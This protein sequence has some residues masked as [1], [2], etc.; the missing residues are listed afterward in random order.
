MFQ[1]QAFGNVL[2]QTVTSHRP[3]CKTILVNMYTPL[4]LSLSLALSLSLPCLLFL[5][6]IVWL[7]KKEAHYKAFID[8]HTKNCDLVQK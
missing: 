3:F 5:S 6:L 2:Q 4:S 8:F 7:K 1:G